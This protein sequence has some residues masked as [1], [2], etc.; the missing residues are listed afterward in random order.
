MSYL[1]DA[2]A[3][4]AWMAALFFVVRGLCIGNHMTRRTPLAYKL[5]V[6]AMT[7]ACLAL[8]LGPLYPDDSLSAAAYDVLIISLAALCMLDRRARAHP[9]ARPQRA[10]WNGE[11]IT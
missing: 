7:V 2:L 1:T 9:Q 5:A 6:V 4:L 10:D 8:V 3:V 11:E